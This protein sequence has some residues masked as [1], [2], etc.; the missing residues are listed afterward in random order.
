VLLNRTCEVGFH[1]QSAGEDLDILVLIYVYTFTKMRFVLATLT[2]VIIILGYEAVAVGALRM[3]STS[4]SRP[5]S[6]E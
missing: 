4:S 1:R 6:W 5:T 2:G 3:L